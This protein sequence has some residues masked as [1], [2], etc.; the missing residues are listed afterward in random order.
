MTLSFLSLAFMLC[1]SVLFIYVFSRDESRYEG[2]PLDRLVN[3]WMGEDHSDEA[4]WIF[5]L[6]LFFVFAA[7]AFA[8]FIASLL[9]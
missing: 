2:S 4:N 8:P 7:P 1:Y 5:A 3:R 9:A 6:C